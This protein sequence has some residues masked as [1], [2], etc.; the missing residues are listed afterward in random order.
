MATRNGVLVDE[1]ARASVGLQ[2]HSAAMALVLVDLRHK[3]NSLR[4]LT[5][6]VLP[7][8]LA[9][10]VI[11]ILRALSH[12]SVLL[13]PCTSQRAVL[14]GVLHEGAHDRFKERKR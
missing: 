6:F 12:L 14:K 4:R 5:D 10:R 9:L 11:E 13:L 3:C 1:G 8:A 7:N 2:I